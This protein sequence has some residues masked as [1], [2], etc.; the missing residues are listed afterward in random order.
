MKRI[1]LYLLAVVMVAGC[2]N[3]GPSGPSEPID[4][5]GH[6]ISK[7]FVTKNTCGISIASPQISGVTVTQT[8]TSLSSKSDG[9]ATVLTGTID[10]SSGDYSFIKTVQ[11]GSTQLLY[12]ERGTFSSNTCTGSST[13]QY[14]FGNGSSCVVEIS[15]EGHRG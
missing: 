11:V 5:T 10:P 14:V 1:G 2:N 7:G 15:F 9:S 4:A 12:S 3:G 6:W 13:G 8:G